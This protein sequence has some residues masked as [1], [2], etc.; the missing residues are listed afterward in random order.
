MGFLDARLGA[1]LAVAAL[2]IMTPG[3][4]MA[5]VTRNTL[6]AGRRAASFTA[7][8][9]GAGSLIWGLASVL[10]I[11]VLLERSAVAFT[12]FKLAGAVY[13]GYLGVR[14][15]IA[16]FRGSKRIAATPQAPRATRLGEE[17][18]F[19]QGLLNNLLNPKAGAIFATVFPQF[20]KPGD[21]P[22]RL[23]LMMLAYEA[24]LLGWLSL[25]SFV[26]S[27]AGHSRFGSRV[28]GLLQGATGAVLLALGVQLAFE[29]Q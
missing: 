21:S 19:K 1:Y 22:S 28:R 14:S 26:L 5:L 27:R 18:A 12:V 29:R 25:Y 9:I 8:G 17:T 11:A 10:G 2:L 24:I 20:I 23:L 7:L 4:D 6:L 3:P 15:L 16:S 13:L